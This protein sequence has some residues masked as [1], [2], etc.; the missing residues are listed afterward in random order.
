M[1]STVSETLVDEGR[2]LFFDSSSS[3][4]VPSYSG[5]LAAHEKFKDAVAD[6]PLDEEAQLFYA[7]TRILAFG[8]TQGEGSE[9]ETFRELLES[10]GLSRNAA[11]SIEVFPYNEPPKLYDIYV[12]PDTTPAG[13]EFR[14]FLAEDFVN[15]LD[16]SIGNLNAITTTNFT[17]TLTVAETGDLPVEI[18][19]GDVL[20]FKSLL[21]AAK[22][23]IQIFTAYDMDINI[24]DFIVQINADAVQVQRDLIDRYNT[25]LALRTGGAEQLLLAKTSLMAAIDTTKEAFVFISNESDA[26]DDDLFSFG[27]AEEV[28]AARFAING[29][30]EAQLSLNENRQISTNIET[31]ILT[32]QDGR[33]LELNIT[34]NIDGAFLEG[35]FQSLQY[36]NV[37]FAAEGWVDS[38]EVSGDTVTMQLAFGDLCAR[39]FSLTGTMSGF[40]I[41]NGT[42]FEIQGAACAEQLSGTFTG[43]QD[44]LQEEALVDLNYLFGNTSKTPLDIRAVLP[45]IDQDGDAVGGTFPQPFF[46]N[47]FPEVTSEMG[48]ADILGWSVVYDITSSSSISLDGNSADWSGVLPV[49]LDEQDV[50]DGAPAATDIQSLSVAMDSEN[51]YWML[52][53]YDPP[54]SP[55]LQY[56]IHMGGEWNDIFS[57][58]DMGEYGLYSFDGY[59]NMQ[60]VSDDP[61]DMA[62]GAVVEARIP[63]SEFDGTVKI[64]TEGRTALGNTTINGW[65][66]DYI[67]NILLR[68]PQNSSSISGIVSCGSY[69]GSG[70][71][72]IRAFDGPDPYNSRK[73]GDTVLDGPGNYTITGLPVGRNVYLFA[74]WDADDNGIRSIGDFYGLS[75]ESVEVLEG[76]TTYDIDII[77]EI[78]A[79][80]ISGTISAQDS[81]LPLANV[82]VIASSVEGWEVESST[83]SN[84][85]YTIAGLMP[86]SYRLW[87]A[88]DTWHAG[89]YY[90]DAYNWY[91]AESISVV[92]GEV[93]GGVNVS[94]ALVGSISGT[95]TADDTGLP[96]ADIWVVAYSEE[97]WFGT[98]THTDINGNYTVSGL[99]PGTYSV[100]VSGSVSYAAEL[101]NNTYDWSFRSPVTVIGGVD[102]GAINAGLALAGSISGTIIADDTGLPLV[103]IEIYAYDSS[104]GSV[105]GFG[106]TDVN[107]N[108]TITGLPPGDYRLY[109]DGNGI[110]IGEYYDNTLSWDDSTLVSVT[111]GVV[112]GGVNAG[113]MSAG[114]ISGTI[115]ADDTGQ[116]LAGVQVFAESDEGDWGYAFTDANGNYTITGLGTG[117]YRVWIYGND[118]N[119]IGEYY[120]NASSWNDAT[121]VSVATGVETGGVNAGLSLGGAIA[122]TVTAD[123]TGLPLAD[124]YVYAESDE[125]GWGEGE[126]ADENGNY[127]ITGLP[128]GDYRVQIYYWGDESYLGEY[129]D[130]T[131]NWE[132]ATW[133]TVTI[134]AVTDD[135]NAAL[136][137]L[138]TDGDGI[139]NATDP[140]DDNDGMPDDWEIDNDLDPL[141]GSDAAL[142][143]D[144]DGYSNYKEYLVDTDPWNPA[145]KPRDSVPNDLNGDGTSDI[146]LRSKSTGTLWSLLLDGNTV[147][148]S[149]KITTVSVDWKIAAIADFNGDGTADIL[150][151]NQVT[152]QL[153][154]YR[155]SGNVISS[156]NNVTALSLVWQILSIADFNGDGKS[157]ILLFNS[158]T[159]QTWMY[160]MDGATITTAGAGPVMTSGWELVAAKDCN[161]D[162]NTDILLRNTSVGTFWLVELDGTTILNSRAVVTASFAWSVAAVEDFNGDGKND[163]LIRNSG[164]GQL[165]M[166]Q[167][168]GTSVLSSSNVG[169]LSLD[170][171]IKDVAD[172][173]GDMKADILLYK[174][175][176]RSLWLYTMNGAA[177]AGSGSV[178]T[179]PVG[180]EIDAI[181]DY[182]GDGKADILIRN[183]NTGQFW[184]Y[185]LDGNTVSGSGSVATLVLDWQTVFPEGESANEEETGS[186]PASDFNGDG[187][188]DILLRSQST[189]LLWEYQMSGNTILA[190]AKLTGLSNDWSVVGLGDFGGDGKGDVLLRY[191]TTGQLWLYQLNGTTIISSNNVTALDL[192]WEV[193]GIA[194]FNGDTKADIL[195]RSKSTGV[196]WQYQMNGNVVSA[197]NKVTGLSLDW[198]IVGTGD[199]GGDG[200][201]DILLRNKNTGQLWLY[202]M[203]G[204][205]VQVNTNVGSLNIDWDVAGV[206]DFNG[207]KKADI[208]LRSMSSGVIWQYQMNGSVI[209]ASAKVAGLS[210]DWVIED[211]TDFG[212]DG[213][214]DILLRNKT[215]GQLWLYQLN[216]AVVAAGDSI[217]GL[218]LDWVVQ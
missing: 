213:K 70:K 197:S 1:A 103:G 199:F 61:A 136:S 193:A 33:Q 148:T 191:K 84:G 134:G 128:P 187:K 120:D 113:L 123:D 127:T 135:I 133:V 180:W 109:V 119:Y 200:K 149:G 144:D 52:S 126:Y 80:S 166:Y 14:S 98:G 94:L 88:G 192:D 72:F 96:L 22:T 151:R 201:G 114:S 118:D 190:S 210:L 83:D 25:F 93:T 82:L 205:T 4:P 137:P 36:D 11:D 115:T 181:E 218:A 21:Q 74:L 65:G 87:V 19:K 86:G 116:P 27:S 139:P 57:V 195:L 53:L 42:F 141:D 121:L 196:I 23:A 150:L 174:V 5:I 31:W 34:K 108:Y 203:N 75:T 183:S 37:F 169:A 10:F 163:I 124:V 102:T 162:G 54:A 3:I 77:N 176:T 211:T 89:E 106:Y 39:S 143:S 29:L 202:Q 131:Y 68:L 209:S 175:G 122:G 194:D 24:R 67:D 208:L 177:I 26:Q 38:F 189:G 160:L 13:E 73:L 17:T 85:I 172:F 56:G 198:A 71:I 130:N 178:V 153:W 216:G 184:L 66:I 159:G 145:S 132:D 9:I 142:D 12:P 117:D 179:L 173:N 206:A 125:N 78:K 95:V 167:L 64:E 215:T 35:T 92:G 58:V 76:G 164:T 2:I 30:S 161:G 168:D 214:G 157:D 97:S 217:G 49:G 110:Y 154:M 6:D 146:L 69:D 207:D 165:W 170:W 100:Y 212:G 50:A 45:V 91:S 51:I 7:V 111:G 44:A 32:D 28:A 47:L 81:G 46:N 186:N 204:F 156:S 112:T 185:E 41:I 63:L 60:L 182:N 152:G 59:G 48:L 107:G 20:Y 90:N 188:A 15:L 147:T 16:A 129:Y 101:Y 104:G 8:L 105:R 18:D 62:V 138:D 99:I 55:S 43:S 171:I 40:Q 158:T 79:G 155:M 140:D